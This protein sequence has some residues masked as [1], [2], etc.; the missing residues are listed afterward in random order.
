MRYEISGERVTFF[1]KNSKKESES[2][3]PASFAGC[4]L[5]SQQIIPMLNAITAKYRGMAFESRI[6]SINILRV[7]FAWFKASGSNWPESSQNWNIFTLSLFQFYLT[8]TNTSQAKTSTRVSTWGTSFVSFL[9]HLKDEE[10]IPLDVVIPI[11]N[12]KKIRSLAENHPLL[13]QKGKR[14]S[15]STESAQKLLVDTSVSLTDADYLNNVECRCRYLVSVI[16]EVCLSHWQKLMK[17][18]ETG[19]RLAAGVTDDEIEEAETEGRYGEFL[20]LRQTARFIKYAS[21]PHPNAIQWALA[22]IRYTLNTSSDIHCVSAEGIR[23]SP[24][25]KKTIL[26]D[27]STKRSYSGLDGLTSMSRDQWLQLPSHA[28]F[29]RFAGLLS[30]LDAAVACCLLTIEHP[31]FTSES[32]QNAVL[33]NVRGKP[34]LLL[35][36]SNEQSILYI[37]KPRAGR[38][39][40]AALSNLAQQIIQDIVRCTA[41][42]RGVLKR[43]GNKTWRYLFLGIATRKSNPGIL[44]ALDAST[45]FITGDQAEKISLIRLYPILKESG[46]GV[47]SFDY[48]RLRNT[49]GIICWFET[50]SILEMSR[51]L[52]NTRKVTLENYL[53]PALLH[54]W[55]TR[56]IRR[57]QNTLIV[58]AAHDEP[59]LLEV[60]DFPNMADLQHFVAQI[61]LDYPTKS[62]PLATEVQSRLGFMSCDGLISSMPE[63]GY[64]NVRLSPKS[65]AYLYSYRDLALAALSDAE[66]DKIDT[67]SGLA[68]RKFTELAALLTRIGEN[69]IPP[70]SLRGI[71]DVATLRTIHEQALVLQIDLD[72]QFAKLSVK[73]CWTDPI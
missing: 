56:I 45:T 3:R 24:F 40:S 19:H 39:K 48:R 49:M 11:I 33:L 52:G 58:L 64:L 66:L 47:G 26:K 6:K 73:K 13:G 2:I 67:Q 35:T 12:K 30:S 65:L 41:P 57:F 10:I 29:Y 59:Y 69:Q 5:A 23:R 15:S 1:L 14:I 43:A 8:D 34:R 72:T 28:R 50:G 61:I 37:D 31:Q 36:D 38:L 54:A 51:R 71:L 32:L 55:N 44:A 68:P 53:P 21:P 46:L 60:T 63:P 27:K 25:F 16:K 9:T 42:V 70:S 62:S 20:P 22:L 18:A 17:D 7:I 4:S